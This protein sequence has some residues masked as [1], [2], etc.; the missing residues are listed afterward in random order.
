MYSFWSFLYMMGC[1]NIQVKYFKRGCG[2]SA[3]RSEAGG[4]PNPVRGGGD[5]VGQAGSIFD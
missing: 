5:G 2:C 1:I 3:Q 4:T